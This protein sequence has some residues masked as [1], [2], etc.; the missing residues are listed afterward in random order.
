MRKARNP[1]KRIAHK[2]AKVVTH[3]AHGTSMFVKPEPTVLVVTTDKLIALLNF[4]LLFSHYF[5]SSLLPYR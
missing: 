2:A 5:F 1:T 4:F 3:V